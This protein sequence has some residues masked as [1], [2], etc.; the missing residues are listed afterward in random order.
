VNLLSGQSN[1]VFNLKL[2]T[3]LERWIP[4]ILGDF[5]VFALQ[6]YDTSRIVFLL[7]NWREESHVVLNYAGCSHYTVIIIQT[8]IALY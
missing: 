2:S 1:E 4:S 7:V 3:S 8:S 5:V 6:P